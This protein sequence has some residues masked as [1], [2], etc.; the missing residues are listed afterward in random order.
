MKK[1]KII[2]GLLMIIA[3][4]LGIA[5]IF[6][7]DFEEVQ[8]SLVKYYNG[9]N[10]QC[11]AY[12]ERYYQNMFGI[13]IQSVGNA[14]NLAEKAPRYGL[15]FHKNGGVVVPQVGDILVFGNKNKVGH[16]AI[17]TGV[18]KDGVLIVEQNWHKAKI[19]NN[20]GRALKAK[21][22]NEKY[23][24]ADRYYDDKK[25]KNKFWIM[26]WVSRTKQNPG[27]FFNFNNKDDRG[28]LPENSLKRISGK[29]EKSLTMKVV[30]KEPRF[31]SPVFLDGLDIKKYN[32]VVFN[33]KVTGN[34]KSTG[35]VLYLRDQNDKWSRQIPFAVD[36]S[37]E[38]FKTITVSLKDLPT[39]FKITQLMLRLS[40]AGVRYGRE[41][42]EI[43]WLRIGDRKT[44]LL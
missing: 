31:L 34:S 33:A 9:A 41:K 7:N 15:Y 8:T 13:K 24:I 11:V 30:G 40:N 5:Y 39:D 12:V 1:I 44:D 16:V 3:L 37:D 28:W 42:W 25:K 19:T 20:H 21:Y 14:M 6:R 38:E 4:L 32:K 27:T 22:E 18:L 10:Y 29:N 2:G 23:T 17:I 43:D 36:F 26:G 35:G